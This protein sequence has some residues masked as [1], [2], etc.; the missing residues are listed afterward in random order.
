MERIQSLGQKLTFLAARATLALTLLAMSFLASGSDVNADEG[1]FV[2]ANAIGG[3]GN[4]HALGIAVDGS[5]NVYTIGHIQDT[6]DFDP[7]PGEFNLTSVGSEDVFVSKLDSNGVFVWAKSMG[8]L[9]LDQG[10]GIAAD[11]SGHVHTTGWFQD[12]VDFDPGPGVFNLTSSG[13]SDAFVTKLDSN[14]NFIWA[15]SMG[16]LGPER[17]NGIAVDASGNVHTTGRFEGEVDFDPGS[18]AF[19]LT[20]SGGSD[21]FVS[22]LD[23]N[24]NFVW[25]KNMGGGRSTGRG[26]SVDGSGNVPT[27][28]NFFG[29]ANFDPGTGTAN[30]ITNGDWDV[31]VSKLDS[32]GNFVWAKSMGGANIDQSN[33]IAVDD[34]GN[35]HTMGRFVG[36][37]DF[38]PGPG[39]FNLASSGSADVFVSKL[40]IDGDFIWARSMGGSIQG[41]GY[42]IAVD[43][44]GT[45]Y[46]TGSFLGT[47]DFDPGTDSF[48]LTTIGRSDVFVSILDSQGDFVWAKRMGGPG[49]D[50][51]AAIAVDASGNVHTT[52]SFRDTADF[53]PGPGVFDLTSGGNEDIFVSKLGNFT[54]YGETTSD[55]TDDSGPPVGVILGISAVAAIVVALAGLGIWYTQRRRK[56]EQP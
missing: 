27:V 31:F 41:L 36:M 45:V 48:S 28:G 56:G 55:L 30:L 1:D 33:G 5:G 14:G 17:A 44:G 38:D 47:A 2:W 8:G 37:V 12:T 29:T 46:T 10:F 26:I 25:A 51:V 19:N 52:G 34:S 39:A 24:G 49:N 32:N 6:V 13:E 4:D 20:S 3:V 7:G 50:Q 42:G 40:G 16:G 9:G 22:K 53:D 21:L 43:T 11:G 35:V 54:S 18:S 15:K 23:S